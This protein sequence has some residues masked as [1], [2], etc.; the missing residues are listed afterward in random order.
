MLTHEQWFRD[1]GPCL[2][3]I[4]PASA[5]ATTHVGMGQATRDAACFPKRLCMCEM[6]VQ[7]FSEK[8]MPVGDIE[9]RLVLQGDRPSPPRAEGVS[10]V[11]AIKSVQQAKSS[12]ISW[13][14]ER[15]QNPR[16]IFLCQDIGFETLNIPCTCPRK[17][18]RFRA[19]V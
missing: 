16:L 11:R 3:V 12:A 15:I 7:E 8:V 18:L 9:A 14:H 19:G 10:A 6:L 2:A 17:L 4:F 1:Q 5:L 13:F